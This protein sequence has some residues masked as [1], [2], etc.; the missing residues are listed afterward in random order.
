[1][2]V[3]VSQFIFLLYCFLRRREAGGSI[4]RH[5]GRNSGYSGVVPPVDSGVVV[6]LAALNRRAG[7]DNA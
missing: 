4:G 1:M 5:P 7:A 3:L 6:V 2:K